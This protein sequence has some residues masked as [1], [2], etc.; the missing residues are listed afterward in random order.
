MTT[1]LDPTSGTTIDLDG[2]AEAV[3]ALT[4][5]ARRNGGIAMKCPTPCYWCDELHE[6]D[7]LHFYSHA[8]NCQTSGGCRHG[9]CDECND[10]LNE[11]VALEAAS[12][13]ME[14]EL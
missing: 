9:I 2:P 8:C 11:E 7:K 13:D 4:E 12:R 1:I 10:E 14:G 5:Y 3:A 6:L